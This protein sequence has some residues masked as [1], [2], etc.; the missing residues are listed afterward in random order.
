MP[1]RENFL[2]Y[3]YEKVLDSKTEALCLLA[4]SATARCGH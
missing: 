3:R 2:G 4:A 1:K